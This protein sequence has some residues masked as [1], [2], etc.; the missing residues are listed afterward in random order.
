M[1][2]RLKALI[3]GV[4]VGSLTGG[5]DGAGRF[6]EGLGDQNHL[7]RTVTVIKG[8]HFPLFSVSA[9]FLRGVGPKS[10]MSGVLGAITGVFLLPRSRR[11][12][13]S[14][15]FEMPSSRFRGN[16][17]TLDCPNN[18]AFHGLIRH[19]QSL[20]SQYTEK[21]VDLRFRE[22]Y[23]PVTE[24]EADGRSVFVKILLQNG[25]TSPE[26]SRIVV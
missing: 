19:L 9:H 12:G 24:G 16:R 17:R 4:D 22:R 11:L 20:I 26:S 7:P 18:H 5:R 3:V 14:P 2:R 1:T 13:S 15:E 10:E 6:F 23:C 25:R 21:M 8:V